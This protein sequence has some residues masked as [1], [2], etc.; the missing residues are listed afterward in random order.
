MGQNESLRDLAWASFAK[1]MDSVKAADARKA[2]EM[3]RVY[4]KGK[5]LLVRRG[6][7]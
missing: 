1:A 5:T 6:E 7:K 4:K 2:A 3:E